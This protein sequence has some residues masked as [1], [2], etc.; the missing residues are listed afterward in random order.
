M[1]KFFKRHPLLKRCLFSL[2]V[3][4][5][6]LLGNQLDILAFLTGNSGLV[7]TVSQLNSQEQVLGIFALGLGPWMYANILSQIMYIG[8][9]GKRISARRQQI[10]QNSLMLVIALIQA[11]GIVLNQSVD[12]FSERYPIFVIAAITVLIGGA[13]ALSWLGSMNAA[14]GVGGTMVIILISILSPQLKLF[15]LFVET[16]DGPYRNIL[17]LLLAWSMMAMFFMILF[18]RSEYRVPVQRISI[19]NQFVKDTFLPVRVN[20]AGGMGMMY[21]FTF[22]S[23]PQSIIMLVR[24]FLPNQL[25]WLSIQEWFSI[26]AL[27]GIVVYAVLLFSLSIAFAFFNMDV[28]EQAKKMRASGDFIPEIRPGKATANYLKSIVWKLS[29]FSGTVITIMATAPLLFVLG[30]QTLISLSSL[31]GLLMMV[32]G[33][34]FTIKEEVDT[35]RLVKNYKEVFR[36]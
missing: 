24:Y 21:A 14:Y 18:E 31:T 4:V 15:L 9:K 2:M 27:P 32:A 8:Q 5:I 6:L 13:F 36:D 28:V 26:R 17:I 30:N 12:T 19:N 11:L 10:N 1:I 3:I 20:L 23:F 16:F 35:Y 25:D 22:L 7:L 34:F 33:I 29:S